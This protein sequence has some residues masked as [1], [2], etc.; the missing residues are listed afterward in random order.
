MISSNNISGAKNC[1]KL[2][3]APIKVIDFQRE[4]LGR[5]AL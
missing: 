2:P 4:F 3:I 1:V 5:F